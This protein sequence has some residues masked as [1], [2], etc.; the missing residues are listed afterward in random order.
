MCGDLDAGVF[1][2]TGLALGDLDD[3]GHLDA[4]F[5]NALKRN[6]RVCFGNGAGGFTTY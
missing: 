1:S 4:V 5:V 3:D 2:S 6:D